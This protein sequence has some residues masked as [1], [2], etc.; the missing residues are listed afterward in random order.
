MG[1]VA[2]SSCTR[3]AIWH[4]APIAIGATSSI[5]ASTL[6]KVLSPTLIAPYSQ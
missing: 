3:V 4:A 5:T 1:Y 2:V 6:M